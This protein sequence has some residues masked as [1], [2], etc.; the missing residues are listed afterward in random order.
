MISIQDAV[1]FVVTS[2]VGLSSSAVRRYR[3]SGGIISRDI[4]DAMGVSVRQV[5]RVLKHLHSIGLLDRSDSV[6]KRTRLQ[7]LYYPAYDAIIPEFTG[8]DPR[9]LTALERNALILDIQTFMRQEFNYV[10]RK[11]NCW[12]GGA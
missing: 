4:A 7:Y 1:L 8:Y 6:Y 2:H 9:T 12:K 10:P 11:A 5:N 3:L